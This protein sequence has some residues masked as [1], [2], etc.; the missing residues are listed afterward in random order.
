[1]AFTLTQAD[2][3]CINTIRTLSMDAVQ[4]AR[5]GHPGTP[6]GLALIAEILWSRFLKFDPAEPQWPDRDRFVLSCGH[7]SMLLYSLLHLSGY[8]VSLD[9]LKSFRQWGAITPGHPEHHMT[10]GVEA[11]TGPLGQ[12]IGNGVGMAM[13]ERLLAAR[14]NAD[15]R[16]LVD[17]RTWVLA[18]DGDMMEGI[19]SE[20]SSLAAHLKLDRLCVIYDDNRITIDGSTDLCMSEDVGKRY[21]AYGWHVQRIDGLD[22]EAVNRALEAAVGEA[23][24][25]SFIVARTHIAYGAPTKQDTPAAHGAPLGEEEIRGAKVFYGWAPDTHFLVP[26]AARDPLR[27][28]AEA[29][30]AARGDWGKRMADFRRLHPEPAALLERMLSGRLPEGWE[31]NLPEF[32]A[33]AKGMA[34]RSASA[35]IIR[36]LAPVLPELVGGSADLAESNKTDIPGGGSVEAGAYAGRNLHFGI[37]EHGMG[38]ILNGLVLHGGVRPFGAT[39]FVFSDYMRPSIRLAAL[40]GLPVIYVLT[41][42]SIGLGEDGPTHQPVEHLASLRAMPNLWV[43][44]PADAN[45]TVEAWRTAIQRTDGPTMLVLSRQNLPVLD[46]EALGPAVDLARGAYILAEAGGGDPRLILIASGS[47]V[48]LAL[49]ARRKLQAE[50]IP[51]RVV[52]F[53]CWELFEAQPDS[54]RETVLPGKVTA[55]LAVEA[56]ATLGWERWMGTH[57]EAVT[58]DRFGA[59]APAPLVMEE[60]GFNVKNIRARALRMLGR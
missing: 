38:A 37:R 57:G 58:L 56:G 22:P 55:R 21:E 14:F 23:T 12:G 29:G 1:M 50:G 39:F 30:A 53:P 45:E 13:A 35:A 8:A 49:E 16:Q 24:R 52:S 9:D 34:T 11:T 2:T 7:A 19:A 60:F 18:S 36:A 15:G 41:H 46:R 32:P 25:P 59:S 10:P 31:R 40:T 3:L 4:K 48:S 54:Y 51:T 33:D 26:P 47:E 20:A 43:I 5:S 17:H 28:R 27:R 6:M 42:D 44:R